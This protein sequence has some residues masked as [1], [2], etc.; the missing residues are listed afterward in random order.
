[1]KNKKKILLVFFVF[2]WLVGVYVVIS[3]DKEQINQIESL[4]QELTQK[5]N[6]IKSLGTK[7]NSRNWTDYYTRD[8]LIQIASNN[9]QIYYIR[10][11]I[12]YWDK[13]KFDGNKSIEEASYE[14]IRIY[15]AAVK[16]DIPPYLLA[17]VGVVEN[18]LHHTTRR[19][20]K[21]AVGIFQL[22]P[23]VETIYQV[24]GAIFEENVSGAAQFLS[25]LIEQYDGD[26]TAVLGHYNGG[27]RP[28]QKIRD[29]KETR[30]Y[31]PEVK[32][33]YESMT[34]KYGKGKE[35]RI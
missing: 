31:V 24:D 25:D 14:A 6:I 11:E 9:K 33:I 30:E 5:D 15:T 7:I 32:L 21:N 13:V 4:E 2:V 35:I 22:T 29:Y 20:S 28:Y 19:N 27:S 8:L 17:A 12:L 10:N 3:N 26:L 18:K 1:M 16:N 34:E 23:I